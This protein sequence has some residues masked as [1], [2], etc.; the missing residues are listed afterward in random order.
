MVVKGGGSDVFGEIEVVEKERRGEEELIE[1]VVLV[2]M[3]WRSFVYCVSILIKIF[4][5][6]F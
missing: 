3:N 6:R 4:G 2:W 5:W 1:V